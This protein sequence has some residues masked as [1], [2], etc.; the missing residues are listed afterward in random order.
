MR[1]REVENV[2]GFDFGVCTVHDDDTAEKEAAPEGH[3]RGAAG[4][5]AALREKH[6]DSG[7]H[8]IE[9]FGGRKVGQLVVGE[10]G[11]EFAREVGVFGSRIGPVGVAEAEAD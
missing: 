10:V 3:D 2:P 9:V 1:S 4:R 11:E 6:D 8:L 5:D 7:K